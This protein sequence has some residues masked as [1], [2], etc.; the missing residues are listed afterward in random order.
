MSEAPLYALHAPSE[1]N[2][3]W[4]SSILEVRNEPPEVWVVRVGGD[5]EDLRLWH[6]TYEGR[7]GPLLPAA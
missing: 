1:I 6:Y 3:S 7:R 5:E 2:K 4:R